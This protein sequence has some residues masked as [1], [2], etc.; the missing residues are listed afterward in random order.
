MSSPLVSPLRAY[1]PGVALAALAFA[2]AS[3]RPASAQ[4]A[5]QQAVQQ[6]ARPPAAVGSIRGTVYDSLARRPLAGATVQAVARENPTAARTTTTDSAGVFYFD[7]LPIGAYVVGFTD[8]LFDALELEITPR[9]VSVA[10]GAATAAALA[11]PGLVPMRAALCGADAAA[12]ARSTRD[13][14]GLLIGVVRDANGA[15][16]VAGSTVVLTWNE[17]VV[18]G[19]GVRIERRRVPV[20][21]RLSGAYAA[22]DVPTD[23]PV[24]ASAQAP[25][26]E[27]GPIE[28]SLGAAHFLRRDFLLGDS[29]AAS[30]A[31]GGAPRT[32]GAELD[33]TVRA[34]NGR[35][36]R[37]ARVQVWGTDHQTVTGDD[38]RFA[39]GGL[40]TGTRTVEVRAIGFV[41]LRAAVDLTRGRA[42][43]VQLALAK[44]AP[45]LDR[46][47]VIGKRSRA[48]RWQDAFLARRKEGLGR[49]FTAA[50]V[51][52]QHPLYT[53]DLLRQAPGVRL[54][55]TTGAGSGVRL[56]GNCTPAVVLDG[57]SIYA[58]ADDVDQ[59]VRPEELAGVEVYTGVGGI[60][61]QYGGL[62]ANGCGA[63]LLWTKR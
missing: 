55:P 13:S 10:A 33:G 48:E 46:V 12:A 42:A 62:E 39:L 53:S 3:A 38:G 32:G 17:L 58:G 21:V 61:L 34:P 49:F 50:D 57:M 56:R 29:A 37:G 15:N 35:A 8:P 20:A 22:C 59:L 14:A 27:S 54:T 6:P 5:V 2:A 60:P 40:P 44:P 31:A 28:V 11:V 52:R 51:E 1:A 25:G 45:T 23:A 9:A 7:S 4:Q 43:S 24:A 30:V 26:R 36:L 41:P 19:Q 63:V 47:R 16:A 18:D